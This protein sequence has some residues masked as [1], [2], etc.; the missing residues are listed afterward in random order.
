M[1][2]IPYLIDKLASEQQ[3]TRNELLC[4]VNDNSYLHLLLEKADKVRNVIYGRNVF[5]RGLIEFSNYCKNDCYYCGIRCSNNKANRYRLSKEA[6]LT[7]CKNGYSLGFRTFVLQSG[8][9]LSYNAETMAQI[10]FN[11]KKQ[12]PDCAITLSIGEKSKEAYQ[13]Y[14]DAGAERFLLRHEAANIA[15]YNK[16]HPA[17]QAQAKRFQA[18]EDLRA[19]GYQVGC[20]FMVGA[21]FQTNNDIVD[22]LMFIQ[23]FK[24]EMVGIGPFIPHPQTPFAKY[25]TGNVELTLKLIA[26]IRQL[27]PTVLLPATTA[28]ASTVQDGQIKGIKA[29]ANVIMPN[30]SPINVRNKY[31]IYPNKT[32]SSSEA[33]EML[34]NTKKQLAQ[35]NFSISTDRGDCRHFK[36]KLD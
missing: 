24:P 25:P 16:L 26:I 20:G 1:N 27:I 12:F 2:T 8:E 14:F 32:S 5:I 7:C 11:I 30:L 35:N 31:S 9:D 34:S 19:I 17:K 22:D 15:L 6:I 10:V 18:L 33:A 36:T 23:G 4:I 3:L 21:P 28:L 13:A 29:G